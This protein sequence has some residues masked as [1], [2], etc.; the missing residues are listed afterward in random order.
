MEPT[1]RCGTRKAIGE[2]AEELNLP[3]EKWMQDWPI[4]VM[5][6]SDIERYI[7]HYEKLTDEDKK[8]VLMEGILDVIEYQPT[9]E[10]FLKNWIRVRQ[11]LEKDFTIHEYTV[12]YWACFDIEN[13]EDWWKITP[14]MRQLWL[15]NPIL[16]N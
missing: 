3:N 13:M 8:F 1:F 6:L 2:L 11:F 5:V 10:L 16:K 9:E 15:D 7:E 14:L 12:Y 4:E